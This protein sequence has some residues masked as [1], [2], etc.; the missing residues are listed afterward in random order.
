VVELESGSVRR[1]KLPLSFSKASRGADCE[2]Y[3]VRAVV[4]VKVITEYLQ[5]VKMRCSYL[6]SNS[7]SREG[8][9]HMCQR[10]TASPLMLNDER[11]KRM[12]R[13]PAQVR[14]Q[15][16]S[17]MKLS[18]FWSEEVSCAPYLIRLHRCRHRL[19]LQ[20]PPSFHR[21][22]VQDRHHSCSKL[23]LGSLCWSP[24][25]RS[26]ADHGSAKSAQVQQILPRLIIP[27]QFCCWEMP[28]LAGQL[29]IITHRCRHCRSRTLQAFPNRR[30]PAV[31]SHD[32]GIN[33]F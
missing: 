26:K 3:C 31:S 7:P 2:V 28:A 9:T 17:T 22:R 1:I 10:P 30:S 25:T 29:G 19:H 15:I 20:A 5:I 6:E 11:Q 18:N 24:N 12:R 14:S 32:N 4:E 27:R 13:H 21:S 33:S 8:D 16:W 23:R